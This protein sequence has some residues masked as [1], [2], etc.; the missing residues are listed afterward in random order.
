M[1]MARDEFA[2]EVR[3]AAWAAGAIAHFIGV[4]FGV[5]NDVFEILVR[6]VSWDYQDVGASGC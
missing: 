1:I 5:S 3:H 6:R 4:G 2:C